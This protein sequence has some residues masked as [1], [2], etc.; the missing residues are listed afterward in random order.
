[1]TKSIAKKSTTGSLPPAVPLAITP[2]F[3]PWT[4]TSDDSYIYE[5]SLVL[6]TA[7]LS[8]IYRGTLFYE[9]LPEKVGGGK[10]T[11][12]VP[13]TAAAAAAR[14]PQRINRSAVEAVGS[15]CRPFHFT[16]HTLLLCYA[17][18]GATVDLSVLIEM[19]EKILVRSY[20]CSYLDRAHFIT[21]VP[22]TYCST[23]PCRNTVVEL[24]LY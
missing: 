11:S 2:T 21:A 9:V 17:S 24:Y 22:C 8:Y 6:A 20:T 7:T 5:L 16:T 19:L 13:T 18:C 12:C 1:M 23:T 14:P 15:W 3:S 4:H 10:S